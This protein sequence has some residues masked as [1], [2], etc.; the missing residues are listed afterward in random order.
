MRWGRRIKKLRGEKDK[1]IDEKGIVT[2]VG[3]IMFVVLIIL[4]AEFSPIIAQA[5]NL[6]SQYF[7]DP[8]SKMI[9]DLI[10]AMMLLGI[11]IS[12]LIYAG[13]GK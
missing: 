3:L 2:I 6:T 1:G 8:I 12:Y 9:L 5:L 7:T 4:F 13:A 10:P 11:V